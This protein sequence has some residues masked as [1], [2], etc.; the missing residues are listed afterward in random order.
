MPD[1]VLL[2]Y[3]VALVI[4]G[5]VL[6][7]SAIGGFG[8]NTAARVLS[9]LG[10]LGF[11]GYAFYLLFIFDG[12]SV[13][14]F[15]YAFVLP[16]I[17]LFNAVKSFKAK[18]QAAAQQ[19]GQMQFQPMQP[20]AGYPAQPGAAYPVGPGVGYPAQPGAAYPVQPGVGYPAQP[21]VVNPVQQ[22]D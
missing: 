9:G 19:A 15:F 17:A 3:I 18:R 6:V 13:R 14:I 10:G 5:I 12:G 2:A 11:I 1:W 8:Q 22:Q 16:I 7:V 21:G 20:G 4:G